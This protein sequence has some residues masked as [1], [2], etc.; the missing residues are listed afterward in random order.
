MDPTADVTLPR[1]SVELAKKTRIECDPNKI[2]NKGAADGESKMG[3]G[4]RTPRG[5]NLKSSG[6]NRRESRPIGVNLAR[7]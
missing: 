3:N 6:V 2:S 1:S 7:I 4:K 5:S